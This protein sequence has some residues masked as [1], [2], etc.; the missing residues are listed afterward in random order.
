MLGGSITRAL[1][2]PGLTIHSASVS[3]TPS[4]GT[5]FFQ[6][7]KRRPIF[8]TCYDAR[9][10]K[11]A[12]TSVHSTGCLSHVFESVSSDDLLLRVLVNHSATPLPS[13]SPTYASK[14]LMQ[15]QR[16][17]VLEIHDQAV[18]VGSHSRS[19]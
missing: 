16:R 18:R 6:H 5:K 17:F 13:G 14:D 2:N 9:P 19:R 11:L 3:L 15:G 4:G 1:S 7:F 10:P 8:R 12:N